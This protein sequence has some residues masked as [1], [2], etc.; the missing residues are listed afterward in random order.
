MKDKIA[1]IRCRKCGEEIEIECGR[2]TA[3]MSSPSIYHTGHICPK[4]VSDS[5]MTYFDLV[6]IRK[7]KI[8]KKEIP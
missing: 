2:T 4:R 3:L 6:S 1:I 7:K 8:N 5:E